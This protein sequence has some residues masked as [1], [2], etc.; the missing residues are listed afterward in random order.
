MKILMVSMF[1]NHFFNW[2]DQLKASHHEVLWIDVFDNGKKVEKIEWV[3]QTVNWKRKFD[4]PGRQF[5]KKNFNYAYNVLSEI[6]EKKLAEIFEEKLVEFKP[7]VVQSFV[8]FSACAPILNVM[9]KY[10]EVRWI[11]SAW[12][13]D[14]Y[15]FQNEIAYLKDIKNV[16]PYVD[17]MFADCKRDYHIALKYSFQGEFLGDFPGG[18]GYELDKNKKLLMPKERNAIL[19]KGYQDL[20]GECIPVLKVLQNL[21]EKL[22]SF[23]I[24]IFGADS[25]VVVYAEESGMTNWSN[26]AIFGNIGRREVM[27]LMERSR[28]YIGNSISDGMPNTLL[29][30]IISGAFPIQSNPGG[31]TAEI[32]ED[33]L[34]GF[35]IEDPLDLESISDLII[36]SLGDIEVLNRAYSYNQEKIRP[37]LERSYVKKKVLE[38]YNKVES[39]VISING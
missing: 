27:D 33:R 38:K 17:Y 9:K 30:A 10:P 21:R 24:I 36:R 13:N 32:I 19:V 8:L 1:A 34:N 23:E 28:I 12:G 7:D 15:Y 5:L 14:L 29:E 31:A 37:K 18:G 22:D 3:Q 35:L 25:Q 20:F 4:Y 39:E 16:L 11:Y 6:F 26:F 2:V